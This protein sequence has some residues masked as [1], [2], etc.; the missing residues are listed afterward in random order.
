LRAKHLFLAVLVVIVWGI[1]FVVTKIC[2]QGFPPLLLCAVR[3]FLAVVPAIFFLPRPKASWKLIAG[4]GLTNFALQ[5]AFMFTGLQVGMPP[6]LASL[7]LQTQAFFTMGLA[8]FLFKER[9]SALKLTGA[10]I[11]FVGICIVAYQAQGS[12]VL[13]GFILTL[14]AAFSW[15]A[16]NVIS[17]AVA[18]PSPLSLVVW[19]SLYAFPPIIVLSLIFEGPAVFVSSFA[20]LQWSTA[21]AVFYLVF[22]STFFGYSIWGYLMNNYPSAT[23]APFSLLIPIVG[24]SSSSIFLH[25]EFP[26]WKLGASALVIAGVAINVFELRIKKIF[27]QV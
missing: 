24:F 25:E 3:F 10:G 15:A 4:F 22:L 14:L 1:N 12:P 27:V 2:L 6:G 11:S 8:A 13:L 9:P 16:G 21:A 7:V 17:K 5:F 26:L 18:T 20:H 23:V 19:G